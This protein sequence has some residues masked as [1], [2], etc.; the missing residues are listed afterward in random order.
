MDHQPEVVQRL[1]AAHGPLVAALRKFDDLG[2]RNG[3]PIASILSTPVTWNPP[4]D[5]L[6]LLELFG[7]ISTGLEALL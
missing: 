6:T 5:G 3:Q 1:Q 7:G 2:Q 4:P